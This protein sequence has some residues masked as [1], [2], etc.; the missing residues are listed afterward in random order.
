MARRRRLQAKV[1][2]SL[3]E[4]TTEKMT[5]DLIRPD[6]RREWVFGIGNAIRQFEPAAMIQWKRCLLRI[7]H[8]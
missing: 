4:R 5:P 6:A 7:E 2:G 3:R 8:L 1:A